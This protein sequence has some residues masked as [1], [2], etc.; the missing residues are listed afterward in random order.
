MRTAIK[1]V[2]G[3]I[4]LTAL[5]VTMA[6]ADGEE[7]QTVA[8]PADP[9][10]R[11]ECGSCHMVYPPGLLPERSWAKM[12]TGLKDH[13]GENATLDKETSDNIQKFL[14]EHAADRSL[15]R[16]SRKIAKSIPPGDSPLR[17]TETLYFKRQHHEVGR[18]VWLRKS[19]G[20]PANCA[21]CHPRAEK[22]VFSED[23]IK[24]P[25]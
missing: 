24:I 8:A 17:I 1:F 22:G 12:M 19:I 25:R 21:A 16:R 7:R 23:E 2:I 20:S 15:Q 9:V 11:A 4:V 13:F 14:T 10:Y 5:G 6:R 3:T 18:K